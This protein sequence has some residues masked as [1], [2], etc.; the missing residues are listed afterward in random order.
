VDVGRDQL[1]PSL[2]DD[3]RVVNLEKTHVR[4]LNSKV[5]PEEVDGCVI[6][7]SFISLNAV[8]PFIHA[9]IRKGGFVIALVK[10]QFEVGKKN[11]GKGGIVRD[12]KL[13]PEVLENVRQIAAQNRLEALEHISSPILGGDGNQE[14]LLWLK[15]T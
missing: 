13:Y 7:V 3:A 2:K 10:P 14:F 11:I 5:I 12:K 9:H 1:H 4:E 15:K 8:F 6:D